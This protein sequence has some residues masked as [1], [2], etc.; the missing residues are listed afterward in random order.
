M[1]CCEK[2]VFLQQK[3]LHSCQNRK[4]LI[5]ASFKCSC[6]NSFQAAFVAHA[7]Y[8]AKIIIKL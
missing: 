1:V 8:F 6:C 3:L 2:S 5:P 7:K 4:F